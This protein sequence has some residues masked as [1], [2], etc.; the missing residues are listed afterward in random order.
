MATNE[1]LLSA[2]NQILAAL[3]NL[4]E[5]QQAQADSAARTGSEADRLKSIEDLQRAYDKLNNAVD[6]FNGSNAE[7][8]QLSVKQK[9][10]EIALA[11][12]RGDST[13]VLERQ[14]EVL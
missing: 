9:E 14:L 7:Q 5:D 3:K 10:A 6:R 4:P 12:A 1:D 8:L 13:D 11:A 2:L